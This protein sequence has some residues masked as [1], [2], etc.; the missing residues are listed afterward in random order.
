MSNEILILS[1]IVGILILSVGIWYW[2]IPEYKRYKSDTLYDVLWRWKWQGRNVVGLWCYCPTCKNSLSFDDTLC[3][4]T[5][6]L[7]EKITYLIC[8]HCDAGQ[9]TQIKGGDRRYILTLVQ[10][11]ILRRAHTKTFI[12]QKDNDDK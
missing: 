8:N 3:R 5:N 11:E 2:K 6:K 10:R 7:N 12:L 4:S 9:I 1:I